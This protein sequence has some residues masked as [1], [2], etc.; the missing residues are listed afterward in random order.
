MSPR[1]FQQNHSLYKYIACATFND[2]HSLIVIEWE[3]TIC[4]HW[5]ILRSKGDSNAVCVV[6]IGYLA[7]TAA[8]W[9]LQCNCYL[10]Q[11]KGQT[12]L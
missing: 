4:K 1:A 2:I 3:N 12:S 9:A 5:V 7:D 6:V 11:N 10:Q 8:L